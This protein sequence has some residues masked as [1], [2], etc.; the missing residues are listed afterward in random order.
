MFVLSRLEITWWYWKV[1]GSFE[2]SHRTNENDEQTELFKED[3]WKR[4]LY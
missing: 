4:R 2:R 1:E 3:L